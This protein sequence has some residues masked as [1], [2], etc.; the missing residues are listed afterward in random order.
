MI[1]DQ[2][3]AKHRVK[4]L[5]TGL[6]Q[7]LREAIDASQEKARDVAKTEMLEATQCLNSKQLEGREPEI[8][9]TLSEAE[10]M[11]RKLIDWVNISGEEIKKLVRVVADLRSELKLS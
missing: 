8:F 6:H 7:V 4:R 10:C 9:E 3:R 1:E 2:E 11:G 5:V